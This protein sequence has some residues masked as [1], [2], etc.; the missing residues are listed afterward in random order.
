VNYDGHIDGKRSYLAGIAA[1]RHQG[2]HSGL[3]DPLPGNA[4]EAA[5][6]RL[7]ACERDFT[8]AARAYAQNSLL[9][10]PQAGAARKWFDRAYRNLVRAERGLERLEGGG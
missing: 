8:A 2:V 9:R 3:L 10:I 6:A 5:L 1:I 4:A 7:G